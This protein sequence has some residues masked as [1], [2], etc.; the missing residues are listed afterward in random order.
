[1]A[2]NP[3]PEYRNRKTD[4]IADTIETR[5]YQETPTGGYVRATK[6]AATNPLPSVAD[7]IETRSDARI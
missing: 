4:T 5:S 1:M 6:P 7:T 3:D 2:V